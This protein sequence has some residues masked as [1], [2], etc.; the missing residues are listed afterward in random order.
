MYEFK[1]EE[2]FDIEQKVCDYN[3]EIEPIF[4]IKSAD[5]FLLAGATLLLNNGII[6]NADTGLVPILKNAVGFTVPIITGLITLG[7][8]AKKIYLIN[9]KNLSKKDL[10]MLRKSLEQYNI[11]TNIGSLSRIRTITS[12]KRPN[13]S[14][15]SEELAPDKCF[16]FYDNDLQI[17][18]ILQR[19]N[20]VTDTVSIGGKQFEQEFVCTKLFI[21]E[22]PELE[23]VKEYIRRR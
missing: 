11:N 7:G 15:D 1:L 19:E 2:Y 4:S 5:K 6:Y 3:R 18:A 17:Q 22:E 9:L 21:L 20:I 14:T 16:V 10:I 13:N 8:V 23:H 12:T